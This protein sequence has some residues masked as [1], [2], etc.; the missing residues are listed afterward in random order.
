MSTVEFENDEGY[1]FLAVSKD[2]QI[3]FTSKPFDTKKNCWI[4]D[5]EDGKRIW[6]ALWDL[7][8][9]NFAYSPAF[10]PN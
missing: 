4:P 2:E 9:L 7:Y 1:K 3:Q 6:I 5:E 10:S 8:L